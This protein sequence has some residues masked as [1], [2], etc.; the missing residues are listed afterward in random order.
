MAKIKAK[1][2]I[3]NR[4]LP[5]LCKNIAQKVCFPPVLAVPCGPVS[6]FFLWLPPVACLVL[7]RQP[8]MR[9]PVES[10]AR[11]CVSIDTQRICKP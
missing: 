9:V 8:H 10:R 4:F 11:L 1:I 2:N 7:R 5:T 6:S 3:K